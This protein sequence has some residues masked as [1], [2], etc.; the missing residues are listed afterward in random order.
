MIFFPKVNSLTWWRKIYVHGTIQKSNQRPSGERAHFYSLNSV[1]IWLSK[2]VYNIPSKF[3]PFYYQWKW[4]KSKEHDQTRVPKP[5]PA[6]IKRWRLQQWFS[7][8]SVQ[9]DFTG[10]KA[11]FAERFHTDIH[12]AQSSKFEGSGPPLKNPT[13]NLNIEIF[14]LAGFFHYTLEPRW[15]DESY[16]MVLETL[17]RESFVAH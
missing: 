14:Y 13:W 6:E 17:W 2:Y 7:N 1:Y 3:W 9:L 4:I 8:I 16:L 15:L 12:E 10:T 11:Y 5:L